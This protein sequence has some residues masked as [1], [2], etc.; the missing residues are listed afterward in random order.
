MEQR[1]QTRLKNYDYS[2]CGYYFITI[3]NI[4]GG[5]KSIVANKWLNMCKKIIFV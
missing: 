2:K 4:V 3:G 1:K 5:Y